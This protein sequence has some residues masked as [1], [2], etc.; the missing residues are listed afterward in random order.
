MGLRDI[1]QIFYYLQNKLEK[2]PSWSQYIF[3]D[4]N[5]DIQLEW[6]LAGCPTAELLVTRM[7]GCVEG[8]RPRSPRMQHTLLFCCV[9]LLLLLWILT[10]IKGAPATQTLI[11][12]SSFGNF[13]CY[14][15]ILLYFIFL[16]IVS[17]L[18][19]GLL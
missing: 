13:S 19:G 3:L 18:E 5:K 8:P 16:R 6:L 4:G 7:Q 1:N 9:D 14:S 10:S 15:L 12:L 11:R 2:I 17:S